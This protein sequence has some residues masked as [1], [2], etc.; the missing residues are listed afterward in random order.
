MSGPEGPEGGWKRATRRVVS[1]FRSTMLVVAAI[2]LI[3]VA[4]QEAMTLGMVSLAQLDASATNVPGIFTSVFAHYSWTYLA[5]NAGTFVLYTGL[6]IATNVFR[7]RAERVR[8]SRWYAVLLL[9]LAWTVNSLDVFVAHSGGRGASGA[10][11]A[12]FGIMMAFC[13]LNSVVGGRQLWSESWRQKAEREGAW[14]AAETVTQ[15]GLNALTLAWIIILVALQPSTI[16]G[17]GEIG[18][19]APAHEV[20][21]VLGGGI[22]LIAHPLFRDIPPR[23]V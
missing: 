5:N 16:L 18:I 17:V 12:G 4:V 8:R 10:V 23:R 6:F 14:A 13:L 20:A 19:N 22:T 1:D 2:L 15:V 11:M 3:C 21:A 9:P 7:S